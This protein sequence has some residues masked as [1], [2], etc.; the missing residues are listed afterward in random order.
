MPAFCPFHCS[1]LA[2]F[3]ASL[4]LFT[5]RAF[6]RELPSYTSRASLRE[7]F[8]IHFSRIFARAFHCSVLAHFCASFRRSRLYQ[9]L[10]PPSFYIS[11][12]VYLLQTT[13]AH[14]PS[15]RLAMI[16][17]LALVACLLEHHPL[18]CLPCYFI[19]IHLRCTIAASGDK[20]TAFIFSIGGKFYPFC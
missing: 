16:D 1:V 14:Y 20:I 13:L 2:H 19:F 11:I 7:P 4:S 6:L 18:V 8:I 17:P 10:S 9:A 12:G 5:S 15:P 3:C